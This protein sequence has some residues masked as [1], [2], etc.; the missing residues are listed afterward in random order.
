MVR[1][2]FHYLVE[3]ERK[4]NTMLI[5]SI[6]KH[7]GFKTT[8]YRCTGG[9]LTIGYGRNLDS[10]GV[11]EEEATFLLN[12]DI[13]KANEA[14]DS[15]FIGIDIPIKIKEVFV[16]MIFQLGPNGF[17]KFKKMIKAAKEGDYKKV[18]IEMMDSLWAI[19]TPRRARELREIV[20]GGRD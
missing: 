17:I 15:I 10:I 8:P 7:E 13:I 12:N 3:W 5:D 18:S 19:Q 6:K 1:R 4:N 14:F 16:E 2:D 11:S 9:K 20:E